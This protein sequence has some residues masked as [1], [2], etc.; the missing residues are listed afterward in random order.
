MTYR[1]PYQHSSRTDQC[2]RSRG[3]GWWWWCSPLWPALA[4]AG[5]P[6]LE[7]TNQNMHPVF[8]AA[9]EQLGLEPIRSQVRSQTPG[10]PNVCITQLGQTCVAALQ[11]SPGYTL[12]PHVSPRTVHASNSSS[13]NTSSTLVLPL[14]EKKSSGIS[15]HLQETL[16]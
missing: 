11:P 9:L 1:C 15:L 6:C 13:H 2:S 5:R 10:S 7:E 3:L 4:D 16:A 12:P 14:E 8:T